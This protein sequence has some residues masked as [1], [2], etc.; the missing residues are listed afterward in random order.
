MHPEELDNI[1]NMIESLKSNDV[2]LEINGDEPL[3][4]HLYERSEFKDGQIGFRVDPEGKSLLGD[5]EGDWQ[6]DW[7]VIGYT[8]EAGDPIFVD[9]TKVDFPVYTAE[10]GKGSWHPKLLFE[11]LDEYLASVEAQG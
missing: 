2:L 7:Y 1:L 10:H 9:I 11:S 3:D 4:V 8:D 5:E 6:D